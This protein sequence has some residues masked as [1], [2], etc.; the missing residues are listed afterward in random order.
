MLL[1]VVYAHFSALLDTI[2]KNGISAGENVRHRSVNGDA[3]KKCDD[4]TPEQLEAVKK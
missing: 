1:I 3:T 4:Y 2:T